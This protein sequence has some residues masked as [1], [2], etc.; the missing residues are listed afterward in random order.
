M[1]NRRSREKWNTETVARQGFAALQRSAQLDQGYMTPLL[2]TGRDHGS[3]G[4]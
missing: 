1:K 2:L 4:G 3:R